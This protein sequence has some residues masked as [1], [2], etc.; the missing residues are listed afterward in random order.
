MVSPAKGVFVT[1]EAWH[2]LTPTERA[3]HLV[4][5][6][7]SAHP[8]WTFALLSAAVVH[9]LEV[10]WRRL[11][12]VFLAVPRGHRTRSCGSLRRISVDGDTP[13]IVGGVR[14]T[15]FWRTVADCL[16]YLDFDEGLA[17]ADSVLRSGGTHE[18]LVRQVDRLTRHCPGRRRALRAATLADGQSE[19]GGESKARAAMA[20][21]GF[22]LPNPQVEVADPVDS[23]TF[24][25]V[26][27]LWRLAGGRLVAGELDGREKYVNPR[28]TGGRSAVDVLADERL[29]ESRLTASVDA[30][31]RFSFAD[32][33]NRPR[34][35]RILEAFGIPRVGP[36]LPADRGLLSHP[37]KR[38]RLNPAPYRARLLIL[39]WRVLA[40]EMSR[41]CMTA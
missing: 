14:V 17:L 33:T 6:I 29:R 10:P 12:Q 28:M 4:R 21:L 18:Q 3:M 2:G 20:D 1:T 31:V 15:S 26:D 13:R 22:L 5:A 36:W 30:V 40:T 38:P 19:S 23:H 24:F 32:V 16:R 27:F 8:G 39:G 7:S 25:R 41:S 37:I 9:G 11:G 34:F 35:A